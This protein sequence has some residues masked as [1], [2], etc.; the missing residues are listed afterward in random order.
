MPFHG[1]EPQPQPVPAQPCTALHQGPPPGFTPTPFSTLARCFARYMCCSQ[2]PPPPVPTKK[3][4]TGSPASPVP[5]RRW[6]NSDSR[7]PRALGRSPAGAGCTPTA[8]GRP[9]EMQS[10]RFSR[11]CL[12]L[13]HRGLPGRETRGKLKALVL[14]LLSCFRF[15]GGGLPDFQTTPICSS[16]VSFSWSSI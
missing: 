5:R 14:L 6:W 2:P 10:G 9:P 16:A 11:V 4:D 1:F 3:M 12:R 8:P 7:G 13:R 15:V